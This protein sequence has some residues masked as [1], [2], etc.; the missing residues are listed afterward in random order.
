MIGRHQIF[1]KNKSSD[2]KTPNS[3]KSTKDAK[4]TSTF[5]N[6]KINDAKKTNPLKDSKANDSNTLS[7]PKSSKS[8]SSVSKSTKSKLNPPSLLDEGNQ[9]KSP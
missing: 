5:K 6:I 9:G 7:S 4:D 8:E 1:Q 2:F 3:V